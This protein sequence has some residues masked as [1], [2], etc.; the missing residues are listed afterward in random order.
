MGMAAGGL[1]VVGGRHCKSLS[2]VRKQFARQVGCLTI[3]GAA[4]GVGRIKNRRAR[5]SDVMV[6]TRI[7]KVPQKGTERGRQGGKRVERQ[8]TNQIAGS[9]IWSFRCPDPSMMTSRR[10]RKAAKWESCGKL[11]GN[12]T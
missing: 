4:G 12:G 9:T 10:R 6:G 2:A 3:Q 8:P 7:E 1:G 5:A 11:V